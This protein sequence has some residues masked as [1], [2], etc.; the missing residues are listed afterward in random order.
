M[1][2]RVERS[3]ADP[4]TVITTY[5]GVHTHPCPI[6]PRSSIGFYR[7]TIDYSGG[8]SIG[9]GVGVGLGG[10]ASSSSLFLPEFNY[11]AQQQ[12]PS[13]YFQAPALP[14]INSFTT[15][16]AQGGMLLPSTSSSFGRDDGLLQDMVI[17]Q[18]MPKP[19]Q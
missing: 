2:K 16:S 10:V 15:N 3:S 18:M 5:E 12:Q 19:N 8:G 14:P 17:S 7:D 6:T 11:Q 9:V 4:S 1:K 13:T